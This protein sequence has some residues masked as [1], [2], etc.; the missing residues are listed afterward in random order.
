MDTKILRARICTTTTHRCVLD[1]FL[2]LHVGMAEDVL[3]AELLAP[4][5]TRVQAALAKQLATAHDRADAEL[6]EQAAAVEAAR[7]SREAVGVE[8]Y[9][10]QQQ[11]AR[12][13]G[14][15][16][17]STTQVK[18]L[19]GMREKA[20]S[21]LKRFQDG[22]ATRK[23]QIEMEEARLE[24]FK[25]ELDGVN[26]TLRGKAYAQEP[27]PPPLPPSILL[28]HTHTHT[29]THTHAQIYL[30]SLA[31]L[32]G[33]LSCTWPL[34]NTHEIPRAPLPPPCP[35]QPSQSTTRRWRPRLR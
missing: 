18:L 15:M 4:L 19:A 7:K 21:D 6:R 29:H 24:K 16:E 14:S 25:G 10:V 35:R 5:L 33:S 12:L 17:G 13:H 3:Q 34:S 1:E 22:F 23:A 2:D 20:E 32:A 27:L 11:L 30:P 8:L 26:D 31:L 28:Q 9:G